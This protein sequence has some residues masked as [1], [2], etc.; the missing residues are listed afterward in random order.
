VPADSLRVSVA[1]SPR[2]GVVDEVALVLPAGATVADALRASGLHDRHP[3]VSL[4]ACPL[5]I[6]G[7]RCR[8]ADL[9]RDRDRI[10]IYRPLQVDP[11]TARRLRQQGQARLRKG[12]R[13][14]TGT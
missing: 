5:G 6:W 13:A 3:N 8:P 14:L 9:L 1:F 2:A 7:S 4:D 10:E 12:R 11:M